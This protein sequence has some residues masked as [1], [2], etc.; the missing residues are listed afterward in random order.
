MIAGKVME[1][2]LP[3][4]SCGRGWL[5][6]TD[7]E[8]RAAQDGHFARGVAVDVQPIKQL[9]S[10]RLADDG[11]RLPAG[12]AGGRRRGVTEGPSEGREDSDDESGDRHGITLRP[13]PRQSAKNSVRIWAS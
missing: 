4:L 1:Y 3:Q 13:G 11:R 7:Y 6:P 2:K 5:L 10:V 12:R 8:G 9:L